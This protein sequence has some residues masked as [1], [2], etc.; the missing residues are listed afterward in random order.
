MKKTLLL[1]HEYYPFKGGVARY[2]YN[3][4]KFF[5]G[6]DYIVVT[7]HPQVKSA[8]NII[9]TRLTYS[10][11]KPSWLFSFFKLK[12]II[13]RHKIEQIFTPNILPLGSMAYFLGLPYVIS[14]HGLDINLALK[15]KPTLAAKILRKAKY[16]IVNTH[17]T[18]K[19]IEPLGIDK[20]KIKVI[21]PGLD[22]VVSYDEAKLKAFRNKLNIKD[23]ERVLLTVGRLNYR[24]GQDLVI[25]AVNQLKD[26]IA[27]KY[28]IIGEGNTK[29]ELK[30]LIKKYHLESQVYIFDRVEDEELIYYYKLADIFVMP[31]RHSDTDIEGFGIAFLEAAR[32]EV[33][34]IAGNSGGA[35]ELLS[36]GQEA[37]LISD[38]DLRNLVKAIR[39]LLN[40]QPEA[41][42][43]AKQALARSHD[44]KD[45]AQQSKLLADILAK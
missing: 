7:D 42:K 9:N 40:N 18:A 38:D 3:L 13:R 23:H 44:F 37:I 6:K 24:K 32:A 10:F 41:D 12:W 29:T 16:I 28:F 1:A 15:N 33:P 2:S 21:Y 35:K 34:I 5:K 36:D 39:Y 11:I 45:A 4:F 27:I 31:H 8:A 25:S 22:F 30:N 43:L 14:L 26:D 19:I 17:N 20:N